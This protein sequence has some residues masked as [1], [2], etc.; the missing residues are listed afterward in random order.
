MKISEIILLL[1]QD[2]WK[3]KRV[4]GSHRHFVHQA[5][6]GLVN[7]SGQ[8]ER[9]LETE[10]WIEHPEAGGLAKGAAMTGY[11]VVFEGDDDSGYSAYSPDLPGVVAAGATRPETETLMIEAMAAHITMLREAGQPVPEPS[12]AAS[13]VILDPAAA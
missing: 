2:G 7:R 9:Y 13:V 12:E 5:K 6:P 8:A 11:V 4:S 10:D 3:L 1:E